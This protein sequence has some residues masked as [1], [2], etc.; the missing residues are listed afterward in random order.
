MISIM[1]MTILKGVNFSVIGKMILKRQNLL[2][3]I[4]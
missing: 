1:M 4:N 3:V 2:F